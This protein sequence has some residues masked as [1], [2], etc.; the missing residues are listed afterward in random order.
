[1]YLLVWVGP[2]IGPARA[3][4][5]RARADPPGNNYGWRRRND[6]D[7]SRSADG[8]TAS[9]MTL[10]VLVEEYVDR[11]LGERRDGAVRGVR[12]HQI[13]EMW[14]KPGGRSLRFTATE[15]LAVERVA[16]TWEARFPLA[17]VRLLAGSNRREEGGG[18]QQ[19]VI[20]A[21]LKQGREVEAAELIA[22]GP[23]FD[24]AESGLTRHAVYLSAEDVVFVF[25]GPEVEWIVDGMVD[26]PFNWR[27]IQALAAWRPLVDGQ[28]RIARAA[29]SWQAP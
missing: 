8:K 9:S 28:P 12:L 22:K 11:A 7:G 27:M 26:E 25:E 4:R 18:V 23:P 29:W 16:F 5:I 19:L 14:L 6:P 10:P 13:G 20:V 15:E 3:S 24:P 21:H 1:V 17:P 2:T